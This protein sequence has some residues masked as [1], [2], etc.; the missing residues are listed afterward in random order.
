MKKILSRVLAALFIFILLSGMANAFAAGQNGSDFNGHWAQAALT[1]A[2]EDSL[3]DIDGS[4]FNPDDAM[5]AAQMVSILCHVLSAGASADLSEVT[6]IKRDDWYYG[7]ASHAVA[8][9]LVTPAHGRLD[10]NEPVTRGKAFSAI[11]NAFQ[12][13]GAA[14]DTSTL[15]SYSDGDTLFGRYRLAAA[16]LIS[17]GYVGGYSGS[18]HI[19][20]NISFAEFLTILYRIISN[21]GTACTSGTSEGGIL[22]SGISSLTGDKFGG[23]VYFDCASSNISLQNVDAPLV[24]LRSDTLKSLHINSSRIERFVIAAGSG[25]LSFSPDSSSVIGTAVIGHGGGTMSLGGS[26]ENVE[27]T[28]NNRSVTIE[29]PI[30]H[31][32]ISGSG[33]NIVIGQ[34]CAVNTIKV[35]GSGADNTVT[36]SGNCISCEIF[37]SNT[38]L[39]GNGTIQNIMDNAADSKITVSA[40]KTTTNNDFGLNNV[41]LTL[42]APDNL[43]S[44]QSLEASVSISA[45]PGNI[46]C[47]GAWYINDV[48]LSKSDVTIGKT[49]S[50][51]LSHILRDRG[52]VT[53]TVT[54]SYVLS[55]SGP[56]GA[57]QE[58]RI[59]RQINLENETKFDIKEVLALVTTGYKGNYTL[60]WAQAND[61]DGAVKTAWVNAKGYSSRTDYLVWVSIAYQR[62]NVFSGS[63]G[64]WKLEKTFIVGTGAAGNDT[65]TGVFKIIGKNA[66]GWTTKKYT[67]KPVVNFYSSAYGFHSRLYK[68]GTTTISDARIGFPVSHGCV[69][70]YDEDIA[71]FYKNIPVGTTV[72][73]Y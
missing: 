26:I 66:N 10:L 39:N 65:P 34:E 73:I 4:A 35:L 42:C 8:L 67:V 18:L 55:Y 54:L 56:D 32:L 24:V 21:H 12:L 44:Y 59:D 31:L 38:A 48:F 30:D 60:S 17:G 47:R 57:Y 27:V 72:V 13:I 33:N 46:F 58:L 28:G 22:M 51:T 16:V 29:S 69:R 40:A 61:Y 5:T 53:K 20:D 1:R 62:V 64:N 15:S 14:S 6:D 52:D 25:D 70:M 71:W 7:A 43:P 3:I 9:G 63:A 50:D 23:A 2:L 36:I 41:K 37:G 19:N 49:T 45:P 11:A 68:P